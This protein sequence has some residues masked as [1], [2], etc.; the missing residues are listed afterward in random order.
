MKKSLRRWV[1]CIAVLLLGSVVARA[2]TIQKANNANDL[3]LT[4]SWTGAVVPGSADLAQWTNAVTGAN[5]VLLGANLSLGGI[6]IMNPGGAVTISGANTLTL[7]RYGISMTNAT[8]NLTINT[9]GLTL[10]TYADVVW[11]VTN[12]ITLTINPT[13]FTRSSRATLGVLGAGTVAVGAAITNDAT[14]ILGTW[15]RFGTGT[16]TR[17]ATVSGGNLVGYSAGTA[18]ATAANVVD[19]TGAVNYDVAAVGTL[20]AGASF[21]TLRYTGAAGSIGGAFTANGILNAG[22]GALTFT[23]NLT[24]GA[25]KELVLTAPDSTR[26]LTFTGTINDGAT[27]AT[28]LTVTGSGNVIAPGY[29]YLQASNA[30]SGVTVVNSGILSI[31]N[32]NALGS[33]N[34]NTILYCNSGGGLQISGGITLAEPLL[35]YG[36]RPSSGWALQ[37]FS[38]NNTLSSLLTSGGGNL[39]VN[40]ASGSQLNITGGVTGTNTF[41]V[42]SPAGTLAFKGGAINIGSGGTFY[43]DT[44]GLV[45]L[46]VTNN[47]WGGTTVGSGTMRMDAANA[48]PAGATLTMGLSYATNG[49]LDLNGF[50]Q[51]VGQLLSGTTNPYTDRKVTS[52]GAATLTVN[53]SA[54]TTYFGDFAG[55]ASLVKSNTGTL[56]LAGVG[57]HIGD[58]VVAGGTLALTNVNALQNSTLDVGASGAQSVTFLLTGA[59]TYNL[60]GLKGGNALDIG[61]NTISVGLNNQ[62]TSYT[63]TLSG[64]GGA[65]TKVGTGT[66]TLGGSNTYSGATTLNGGAL[67]LD[68]TATNTTKLADAA[69]LVFGTGAL[70]LD[71]AAG[72]TGTHTELVNSVTLNGAAAITRG[73]GS[74]AVLQMNAITRNSGGSVNFGAANI[75]S[76]D[77]GNNNGILGGWATLNGSDWAVNATGG[78]DGMITNL[79]TYTGINRLGGAIANNAT[80]NVG[81]TNGGSSGNITLAVAG[82]KT[83][84]NTLKMGASAGTATVDPGTGETLRLGATGGLL[85]ASGAGALTIGTVAND[86]TLTAGGADNTAADLV[87]HQY[88]GNTLTVNSVIADNGSGALTLVHVGTGT[89]VLAGANTYTGKTLINGG[90][91]SIAA[92]TA[93]GA[94]P[95]SSTPDQLTLNGGTLLGT[96][97]F[98]VDDSNRGITLGAAGGTFESSAS[99][100][101]TMVNVIAGTGGLTKTGAGALVLTNA[102]T[103]TGPTIIS[104]GTLITDNIRTGGVASA[105]G[106]SDAAAFNLV[107]DGGTLRFT[108]TNIA[109][110]TSSDRNFTINAGKTATIDVAVGTNNVDAGAVS[111]SLSGNIPAT[112]GGL[113]KTGYGTLILTG[114]NAYDGVTTISQGSLNIS[115]ANALGSTNGGT[116]VSGIGARLALS[117]GITL[118]E[119]LTL[120]SSGIQNRGALWNLS[121]TNTVISAIT[122]GSGQT[123]IGASSGTLILAGGVTRSGAI[124]TDNLLL[125]SGV[126]VTNAPINMG[127]GGLEIVGAN[128][129]AVTNN[130]YSYLNAGWGTVLR[131]DVA[132]AL[133]PSGTLEMGSRGSAGGPNGTVNLNGFDQT[134][135]GLLTA[136]ASLGTNVQNRIITSATPATLT[137]NQNNTNTLYDG[138]MTGAL[139]LNKS[140]NGT[141]TLSGTNTYTGGTALAGGTLVLSNSSALGP[142]GTISFGGGTLQFSALN[143]NDYSSR[144]STALNQAY[145]LDTAGQSVALTNALTSSGGSLTKLGLGTLQ[146]SGVNSYNGGTTISNGTLQIGAANALPAGYALNVVTPTAALDLGGYAA[147]VS[148]LNGAGSITNGSGGLTAQ[149]GSFSG[150]ITGSGALTKNGAGTLTLSGANSYGGGTTIAE[151]TLAMGHGSALGTSGGINISSLASLDASAVGG[152]FALASGRSLTNFG[153]FTGGLIIQSG[154]N[155]SGGGSYN[156]AVTNLSGGTLTPGI[157]GDTNF[158]HSL[159]L[160]GDS[161]NSFWIGNT[162]H[163]MSV[164][165]NSF[166]YTG[167]GSLMPQLKL[168][169]S[170]YSWNRGDEFVLYNNLFTGPSSFDGT[171]RYFQFKDA[172]GVVSNLYN[173]ALFS[174]ITGSGGSSVTNLFRIQY[175]FNADG[176]AT[177]NDIMLQ[178]IP[179]PASFNLLLMLGAGY[180][181][182]RRLHG[183]RRRW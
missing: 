101:Q 22:T 43:L 180:W 107:F 74:S 21:N 25:N 1:N 142:S 78:A 9:S 183:R 26:T 146:L 103:Y 8:Q 82:G 50:N 91:I 70:Q 98:S 139:A 102:N 137:V 45:T 12:N 136:A 169:F 57:R 19:T 86:G 156:G 112:S 173:N 4:T 119:P 30:Y 179:E 176:G 170:G 73:A 55:A 11:N 128:V 100:T 154:A 23:N 39:R 81:I 18:A 166:N 105:L 140:G 116:T 63:G 47:T 168:D 163:D 44:P 174:A 182:R 29:V 126:L 77:T 149:S 121:G 87:L 89:T 143:T 53:Q 159:T 106:Q 61:G 162:A 133:C 141:L 27:G 130:T 96:A 15:A 153:T 150:T 181:M 90:K 148:T 58:T 129:L 178:A 52:S 24:I 76:T 46:G 93:L 14:G 97:N 2:A 114:N 33:T 80:A 83:T 177:G 108:G 79:S 164:I 120:N 35:V 144:F 117:G 92:E 167:D 5:S 94:N 42:L 122:V 138:L 104:A 28:N 48:L 161:T 32:A 135:G 125:N 67:V 54:T 62:S 6:S 49:T 118:A 113:T 16:A 152:G 85:L 151:G 71:R 59:N 132:G 68:Y 17:Y 84:I 88:S 65:L 31:N 155:V 175:D 158:F 165:T 60:G 37:S 66:L 40:V 56:K 99:T 41:F 75:A 172:F 13:T 124:S 123:R 20:G 64:A 145:K 10:E 127:A 115:H 131:T 34:G 36:E 109:T 147:S 171:T 38:G 157:G 51:T 69:A 95:G 3:N 7:G 110:T 111:L 72:A 160:A 134:V